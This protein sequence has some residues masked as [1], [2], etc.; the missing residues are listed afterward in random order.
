[1]IYRSAWTIIR[2]RHREPVAGGMLVGPLTVAREKP[3]VAQTNHITSVAFSTW[4]QVLYSSNRP[5]VI[6]NILYIA[7]VHYACAQGLGQSTLKA[8]VDWSS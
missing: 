4:I 3:A 6:T 2:Q 7:I 5:L 8:H 1:M